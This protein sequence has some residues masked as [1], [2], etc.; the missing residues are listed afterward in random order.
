[1]LDDMRHVMVRDIDHLRS[2]DG[3]FTTRLWFIF[4]SFMGDN[5]A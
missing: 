2:V 1:M 4:G 3:L 5:M